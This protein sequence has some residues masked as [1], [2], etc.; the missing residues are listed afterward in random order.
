MGTEALRRSILLRSSLRTTAKA[1]NEPEMH[2]LTTSV[3]GQKYVSL[4]TSFKNQKIAHD[5]S[6]QIGILQSGGSGADMRVPGPSKMDPKTESFECGTRTRVS[7]SC[8]ISFAGF[9]LCRTRPGGSPSVYIYI[10][11]HKCTTAV[12][13]FQNAPKTPLYNL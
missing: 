2:L 5:G 11:T 1:A 13:Y 9:A 6:T 4:N 8:H 7:V 12:N 10:Y 3:S